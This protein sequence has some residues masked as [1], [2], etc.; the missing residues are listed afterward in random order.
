MSAITDPQQ[1]DGPTVTAAAAAADP[2]PPL[3]PSAMHPDPAHASGS[4]DAA[5]PAE[6]ESEADADADTPSSD[7]IVRHRLRPGR[8]AVQVIASLVGLGL[9]IWIIARAWKSGSVDDALK[10]ATAGELAL[11]LGSTVI[12]LAANGAMFWILY[13][14]VRREH[15][16]RRL[17]AARTP[18][19]A[20]PPAT[21]PAT[22]A[23]TAP[24]PHLTFTGLFHLNTAV[25]FL[26]YAPIRLGLIIRLLYHR[27][28]D[29]LGLATLFAWMAA[30]GFV[31]LGMIGSVLLATMLRPSFDIWW[32]VLFASSAVLGVALLI[33]AGRIRFIRERLR[34]A[35]RYFSHPVGV[36]GSI[37]LRIIDTVAYGGR[38]YVAF[39]IIG[40]ELSMRDA[41]LLTL[42]SMLTSM[43]LPIANLGF[44]DIAVTWLGSLLT[45]PELKEFVPG[46]ALID[47][48][49]EAIVF[50]PFGIISCL[51]L[52][53]RW[54]R[55]GRRGGPETAALPVMPKGDQSR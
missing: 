4:A 17:D 11:L 44:R 35:D 48:A 31:Y 3:A 43:V 39:A 36:I 13:E 19:P 18:A 45:Q 1:P 54:R 14:P 9:F 24:L 46:A 20:D 29:G 53:Q 33:H 32:F 47:R 22:T 21:A 8:L 12:S 15:E 10:D 50:I 41:V 5:A 6:A 49:G 2:R 16:R 42:T 55:R 7:A 30:Y 27:K 38:L 25:S 28:V 37:A 34:G 51:W 40:I 23:P 26:N 52:W